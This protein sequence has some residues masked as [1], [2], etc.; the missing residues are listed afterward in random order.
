[1]IRDHD[2]KFTAIFDEVFRA[3]GIRV[4][5]TAPQA[6]QMNAIME[7]QVGSV[8]R[9]LLDRILIMNARHPRKVL[10]EYETHFNTHRPHRS[11]NQ[12]SPLRP[13][14]GPTTPTPDADEMKITRRDRLGGLLHEYAQIA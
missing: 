8:R 5:L 10:T 13:L 14:P 3:E 11:L 1:M 7:C 12:T 9:E 2:A 6:P 4:L